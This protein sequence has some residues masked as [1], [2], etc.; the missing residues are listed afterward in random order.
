M[1][2]KSGLVRRSVWL[3][4]FA[5]VVVAPAARAQGAAGLPAAKELIAKYEAAI[6][7]DNWKKHKSARMKATMEMAGNGMKGDMEVVQIY[8]DHVSSKMTIT[9]LG[10]M[11]T[12]YDGTTAWSMNPMTGPQVLAGAQ[13]DALKESADPEKT[14]R[15]D[16]NLTSA[17]TIEKTNMGGEDC[18]KVK[19]TWKNGK[20]STDCYSVSSGLLVA[21]T[22]K[23][24]TPMGEIEST[25]YQAAYKDFGGMKRATM[26]T[27][28]AMGQRSTITVTAWEWD[29][30]DAKEIDLPAEIKALVKKP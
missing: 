22:E 1:F 4:A 18:Y 25:T 17:E 7:G 29:N 9:G 20:T 14:Q 13:A 21:T 12:G 5:S 15:N 3:A 30:V 23:T 10:D 11:R 24:A 28:E 27:Q 26:I 6:G 19:L 16:A 8:P 2:E